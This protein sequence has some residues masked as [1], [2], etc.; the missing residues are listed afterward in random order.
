MNIH[1]WNEKCLGCLGYMG[2]KYYAV[3]WGIR[4]KPFY[5]DPGLNNQY[6][7]K[8]KAFFFG[9][10]CRDDKFSSLTLAHGSPQSNVSNL[11]A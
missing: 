6:F 3:V 11:P 4:I 5:Q 10:S 1:V 2:M 7:I 9:G 8:N